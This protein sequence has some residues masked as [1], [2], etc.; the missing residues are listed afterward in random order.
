KT[1]PTIDC[2][3]DIALHRDFMKGLVVLGEGGLHT[4]GASECEPADQITPSNCV[5]LP[6]AAASARQVL[7]CW[8]PAAMRG[9][10]T[11]RR[12]QDT[13]RCPSSNTADN[14]PS[15]KLRSV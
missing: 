6:V 14:S 9:A 13:I 11:D 7:E 12:R 15:R 3:N 5:V 10:A 4:H 2:R 8:L 1:T